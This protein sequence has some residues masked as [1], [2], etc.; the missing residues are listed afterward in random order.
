VRCHLLWIDG[1]CGLLFRLHF[2]SV[3]VEEPQVTIM[4]EKRKVIFLLD[5]G[6]HFSVLPFSLGPWYN[7][8]VIIL[9]ISGQ[10]LEHYFTWPLACSCRDLHFCHFFLI[11]PE[12]PVSLLGQALICQ[13]KVQTLLLPRGY[14]CCPL[15]QEQIDPSQFPHQKQ[16]PLKPEG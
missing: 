2:F 9:G 3:N 4:V 14:L 5:S 6:A 12:A 11:V 15:L 10:P 7:N 1:S 13:L 8:K 16:Y